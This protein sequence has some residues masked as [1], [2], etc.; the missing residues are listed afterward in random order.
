LPLTVEDVSNLAP[1]ARSERLARWIETEKRNPFDR[2]AAPLMRC[3]LQ[4][5][6][7][8]SFQLIISF[9]HACIDGWSLAAL[10]TEL[11]QDYSSLLRGL[12]P[13]TPP[14]SARYRDFIAA[15]H[16]A[17]VSAD[18]RRFWA[19]KLKEA[20]PHPLPR[21]PRG[22]CAGG[23]EQQR[24]REHYLTPEVLEGLKSL[25]RRAGVPLK[26]VLLA[27][28]QRVLGAL[29]GHSEI[30][31][32]L[33]SNGRPEAKDGEKVLGLFLNTVPLR[34]TLQL[35]S[36]LDLVRETFQ[37][38]QEILPH[39]RF[40]L[41]EIQRLLADSRCRE[42]VPGQHGTL[43]PLFETAFDFVHFHVYKEL[44]Y[45][46]GLAFA[47]GQYFEA[48]NLTA[49][50]T[51]MLD[52]TSTRLELHIDYDPNALCAEQVEQMCGYYLRTIH[53]MAA[54]PFGACL[55]F[56]P[57]SETETQRL[58]VDWNDTRRD[59][60]SGFCVHEL[61]AAQARQKPDQVAIVCGRES[62]TFGQLDERATVLAAHLQKLQ[63]Q[64]G[65]LVGVC[66]PRSV[67]LVAGLLAILKTGA[68]YLPFD[69]N[70]PS[71]RTHFMIEDSRVQVIL[72]H[73]TLRERFVVSE[74]NDSGDAGTHPALLCADELRDT[75]NPFVPPTLSPA[76]LAYVIFTSGSTGK[77]K[78]VQV[79]HRS[80]V[81]LLYSAAQ[82][83]SFSRAENLLAVT[84]LSFDIAGLEIFL[85]LLFGA[86]LTLAPH[87][88]MVDAQAMRR[89]VEDSGATVMQATPALW[90]LLIE[91]GWQGSAD[92]KII[93]GGDVLK[94]HLAAQLL[95]RCA[96]AWNFY[97]PTETTIWSTA[98]KVQ[99][100]SPVL[101]GR[102][103]ANTQVYI[104]NDRL[105]P[106]PTGSP[107]E[108]YI[109]GDG[110][111]R[112]YLNRPALTAEKFIAG[113]F[114]SRL[115]RTGDLARF[116]PE[117]DIELLGRLDQQVKIRGFRIEPGEI[118]T[119]L[120]QHPGI[121]DALITA[122]EDAHGDA[123]LVGYLITRNG[124]PPVS[125]LREFI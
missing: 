103:L 18:S 7:V 55:E 94:P 9:H 30:I 96:S 61:F 82:T 63:V 100:S 69:P 28:H 97:G 43:P 90:Q 91:A 41:S 83:I 23:H 32:G 71:E 101:I 62:L 3:H 12:T 37:A 104:L 27:A 123:R 16:A 42:G 8:D 13:S 92:L 79:E 73:S 49:Y 124:P 20:V 5:H 35:G 107:G 119:V 113:P 59:Y 50:T 15:E 72:T 108:L 56:S 120:R 54:D 99:R 1:Q 76:A 125:D 74:G 57:L 86:R 40:P 25:A 67:D 102:P 17:I 77:P 31:T 44:Q 51:F 114:G 64:P 26:T 60:P 36:W 98:W 75:A 45:C 81:N 2:E 121:V 110:L 68:A 29:H 95:D 19:D 48:N 39:R 52:T 4:L 105:Q 80:V 21:W 6:G 38:E 85:P 111:A 11:L 70:F 87:D 115:Y 122:H 66:L 58:L 117:G 93:V 34:Q 24:S 53:T 106:V 47:E 22:M 116:L 14:P 33:V 89:V 46:G 118:E 10:V 84:T 112:G 109:G 65:T 78:A 88:A